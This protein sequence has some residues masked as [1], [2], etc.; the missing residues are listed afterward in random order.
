MTIETENARGKNTKN[1]Y[2]TYK[3]RYQITNYY[4]IEFCLAKSNEQ[5][6]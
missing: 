5:G 4:V 1:G 2:L 6:R 3:I